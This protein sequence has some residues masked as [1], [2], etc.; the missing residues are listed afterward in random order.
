[1]V[2]AQADARV[3]TRMP[4]LRSQDESAQANAGVLASALIGTPNRSVCI[5]VTSAAS[6]SAASSSGDN[7]DDLVMDGE[8]D[9]GAPAGVRPS[10]QD[11]RWVSP[12][13]FEG[14]AQLRLGAGATGV[15]QGASGEVE[16]WCSA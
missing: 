10:Q 14:R 7:G 1:M 9:R 12:A 16:P 5:A 13:L 6:A 3:T 2:G 11:V 8:Q 4:G 15:L